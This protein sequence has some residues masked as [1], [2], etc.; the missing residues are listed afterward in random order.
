MKLVGRA[1]GKNGVSTPYA[2]DV[3]LIALLQDNKRTSSPCSLAVAHESRS[4]AEDHALN[5]L[6]AGHQ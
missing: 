1:I 4:A 2:V 5:T 6:D 3:D